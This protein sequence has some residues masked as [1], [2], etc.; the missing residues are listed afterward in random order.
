MN[1]DLVITVHQVV[2]PQGPLKPTRSLTVCVRS[3]WCDYFLLVVG[4][5]FNWHVFTFFPKQLRSEE[6]RTASEIRRE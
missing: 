3:K 1:N 2:L 6:R 5:T 4:W